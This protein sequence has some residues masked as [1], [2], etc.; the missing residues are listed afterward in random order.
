MSV[1]LTGRDLEPGSLAAIARDRVP[2]VIDPGARERIAASAA[3]V[4]RALEDGRPV[5]GVTT[6]LGA[7]VIEPV[8]SAE[9]AGF[10]LRT[11]RGRA[12][13]V[14]PPLPSELSRAAMTVRLN[15]LCAGGAG[16]G[17]AVAESLA[18]LL[19]AGVDPIIPGSGSIGAADLCLLAHMGLVLIGEGEAE[20]DGE[21]LAGGEAL[22]RAGLE[23]IGL[24]PKDGLA[25]CSSSA[26]SVGA[27]ALAWLDGQAAL[28]TAQVSAALAM[29]GF[30]A[31][32]SP[33]D[34]RVVAARP[35]PGQEW[36]AAGLRSL[37]AGGRL[38]QPG[39]A[40]RL[41]DP[42]SFR[43][44]SQIHGALRSALGLLEAALGPELSGAADN[45]LVLADDDEILSTGNFHLPALAMALDATAI[46]VA[47]VASAI[48]ERSARLK[49]EPLSGLPATL[50]AGDAT[51]SGAA[52]LGKTAQALTLEIRHL[53]APLAIHAS[54]GADG[55]E[56]DC[57]GATQAAVRLRDQVQRLE[58]VVA[59]ELLV[60]AQAIELAAPG[61][62]GRGTAA[63]YACVRETVA[64]LDEDRPLGPEV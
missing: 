11:L 14:G 42:L 53:A 58:L 9:A 52:P 29:E 30:R 55:V 40:R 60:A 3:V 62:L 28:S 34:P 64:P 51:R 44:A 7:R 50:V 57:T 59:I 5:Y 21:R 26:V 8:G 12:N 39:G 45:P 61:I 63:A 56:D 17:L 10:S 20:L 13:A 41:Q 38:G 23:P 27:A 33:L 49:T 31:N 16:A 22:R 4:L 1:A 54:V 18:G 25:L 15:G 48:T 19:N 24:G 32:L 37:L 46:A 43:C 35:A 2:V 47:Q 6:G 36:A